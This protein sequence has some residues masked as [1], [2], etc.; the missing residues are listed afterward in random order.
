[1]LRQALTAIGRSTITQ[2]RQ[3]ISGLG[4]IGKTQLALAYAYARLDDYDL[5][6]WLRAEEPSVLAA[7]FAGLAPSLG[8]DVEA[9]DQAALIAAIRGKLECKD[10][11]LLVFD[12]AS[13]PG[14]LNP[15]LPRPRPDHLALAGVG[16][17]GGGA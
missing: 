10:R 13:E 4:G 12:N 11:W 6:R 14:T 15:Y 3:A 8:L 16:G 1:M 5:V 17:R 7:D 9:P 2:S